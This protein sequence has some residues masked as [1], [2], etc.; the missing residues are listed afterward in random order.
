MLEDKDRVNKK[1]KEDMKTI[2]QEKEI[3]EKQGMRGLLQ[4]PG[5]R[6]NRPFLLI[7]RLLWLGTP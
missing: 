1:F 6:R 5:V 2:V 7:Q 3:T 4:Y